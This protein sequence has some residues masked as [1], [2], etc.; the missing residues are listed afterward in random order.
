MSNDAG[1]RIA[2]LLL[3]R[4][5][6]AF[7][8]EQPFIL[9][10]GW[11]SPVY[12]DCR[13]LIGDPASRR[14]VTEAAMSILSATFADKAFDVIVGAETSGIP[15]ATMLADAL[16]LPLAFVRKRP[17]GIGRHAQVEGAS[18]EGRRA[19]L[20]DDLTTDGTSKVALA[21]GLRTAGAEVRHA[22]TVF[23]NGLFPG[24]EE[25]LQAEGLSLLSLSSWDDIIRANGGHSLPDNDRSTL[26]A[27]RKDPVSWSMQ[28]GGRGASRRIRAS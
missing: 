12:V 2:Q 9:A 6:I 27:F 20:V 4:D 7:Q 10:A 19:L 28:H 13:R 5:A 25:R 3:E 26:Q 17:L 21:R 15:F 1:G 16:A 18:V 11:A 8:R 22:L 14:I 24:V 23:Y